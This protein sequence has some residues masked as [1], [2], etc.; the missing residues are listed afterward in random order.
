MNEFNLMNY[1][2]TG[3]VVKA[4]ASDSAKQGSILSSFQFFVP[5]FICSQQSVFQSAHLG[6]R[7]V[8]RCSHI[9]KNSTCHVIRLV[10]S[11]IF[12]QF[13]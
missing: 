8:V 3:L 11:R 13:G 2:R 5:T 6:Q 9:V 4:L 10:V 7:S 1:M 12:F